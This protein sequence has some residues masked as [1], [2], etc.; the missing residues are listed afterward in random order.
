MQPIYPFDTPS[1]PDVAQVG[2]KALSLIAMTQHGLPVPP[3]SVLTVAFFQPW[4][5]GIL[6]TPQWRQALEAR[7]EELKPRTE[8]LKALARQSPLDSIQSQVLSGALDPLRDDGTPLIL[9]VR[10]SSPEEDLEELSFAGGYET[11]LGV[12]EEHLGDAVRRA[13]ASC[14]DE[15]V[16]AYKREHGLPVDRPRIAVIVQA[17]IP[18]ETAGVAFSLNPLNNSY[19]EAVINA[20][21]GLG[22]SVVSGAITPDTFIVDKVSRQVIER[23]LG[24]KETSVWVGPDGG[25]HEKPAPSRSAFCLSDEQIATL[26]ETLVAVEGYFQKPVDI[27]WAFWDG[28]LYLLQARPIT[29]YFPLHPKLVTAP[30]KPKR[31]YIDVTLT[32]WGMGEPLSVMGT[33]YMRMAN[34]AML[35]MSFGEISLDTTEA[36]RP[37]V[38]GRVY[39]SVSTSLKLFGPK[40]A[41][42]AFREM[43]A[44]GAETLHHMDLA[45][46]IPSKTAPELKGILFKAV[47]Q[48]LGLFLGILRAIR[49]PDAFRQKY[50]ELEADVRFALDRLA[51]RSEATSARQLA[52]DAMNML[53]AGQYIAVFSSAILAAQIAKSRMRGIFKQDGSQVREL[54]PY[55]ERGLPDNITVEMGLAMYRLARRP[56]LDPDA[57][58]EELAARLEAR[59]LPPEF[60]RAWD[61]FVERFGFRGP[62]EMDPATPRYYERPARLFDQLLNLARNTDDE[63]SPIAIHQRARESRESA[64]ARLLEVARAKGARRERALGKNYDVFVKLAG[65]RE[66]PKYMFVLITDLVRRRLLADAQALV[67]SG[68]LDHPD[69]IFDLTFEDLEAALADGS[70]DLRARVDENT[71]YRKKLCRYRDLPHIVDSRGRIYRAPPRPA[72]EGELAGEPISPGVVQGPAKV[73]LRPDDKPVLPGDILVARATDPGWTPLF[74]NASGV[75]LE[76]GGMLQHGALVAR[77]Y[78]KPCVAGIDDATSILRDGQL[79]ELDGSNGIIRWI[80]TT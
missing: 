26:T 9:A 32:K 80:V 14:L 74:I 68:R 54:L 55:L 41:V 53:V 60:L 5:D 57:S 34:H 18:A 17:Q 37:T 43:D 42:A 63:L 65:F 19:D 66:S 23:T 11:V 45:P 36:M 27:E 56:E 73:L 77:E 35:S 59:E 76:V 71:R 69:Q 62:M 64:Y 3:G 29:A 46:F 49:D 25:T 40:R 6:S 13:F 52:H 28:R 10:S 47:R 2:G 70:L 12:T 78:G 1:T 31:L 51:V 21:Y 50:L 79:I 20:N 22:E 44:L 38:P 4:L 8:A 61:G 75:V 24:G 72:A 67:A 30:G 15:R 16:F 39:A 58:A 33:G 7:P 48:N